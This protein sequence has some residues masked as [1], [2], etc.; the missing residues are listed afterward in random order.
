MPTV[1]TWQYARYSS[2]PNIGKDQCIRQ[3]DGVCDQVSFNMC[4]GIGV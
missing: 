3:R 1:L 2:V 4:E